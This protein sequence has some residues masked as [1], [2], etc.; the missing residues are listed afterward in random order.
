MLCWR[1]TT[2]KIVRH[3]Y[4]HSVGDP[5][6]MLVRG[7]G[8]QARLLVEIGGGSAAE[9][10]CLQ[11]A[12][13]HGSEVSGFKATTRKIVVLLPDVAGEECSH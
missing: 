9:D 12:V 2:A 11:E 13:E 6:M 7:S 5:T 1:C 8:L 4:R 10:E 3:Q